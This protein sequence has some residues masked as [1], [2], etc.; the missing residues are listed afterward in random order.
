M[1]LLNHLGLLGKE[2]FLTKLHIYDWLLFGALISAIDP[3]A[4]LAVLGNADL[5]CDP[6]L[7]IIVFG[8]AVLNDAVSI[9]LFD[10][11][12]DIREHADQ[13]ISWLPLLQIFGRFLLM[14]AGSLFVGL[15]VCLLAAA[16]VRCV[17]FSKHPS[18]EFVIILMSSYICY[19]TAEVLQFSGIMA[20]YLGGII[21]AHYTFYNISRTSQA[22]TYQLFAALAHT[23]ET[24]LYIYVGLSGVF[25]LIPRFALDYSPKVIGWGLLC[26]TVARG[27]HIFP[28]SAIVN[29]SRRRKITLA[30]Q[31]A[32]WLSGLRGAISF[33]LSMRLDVPV[34]VT[35]T[36]AIVFATTLVLGVGSQFFLR[37]LGLIRP[38]DGPVIGEEEGSAPKPKQDAKKKGDGA[39][40]KLLSRPATP[41]GAFP[42]VSS[43]YGATAALPPAPM[44]RSSTFALTPDPAAGPVNA[45][46]QP[47]PRILGGGLHACWRRLD[48]HYLQ[49]WFGGR[50]ATPIVD[51]DEEH[52][53]HDTDVHNP[54]LPHEI[55]DAA[56]QEDYL[57]FM[58]QPD[59]ARSSSVLAVASDAAPEPGSP[60]G[61][62]W[63]ASMDSHAVGSFPRVQSAMTGPRRPGA[64][65][66]GLG[67]F[68]VDDRYG[69]LMT[70]RNP[71]QDL[72]QSSS[73]PDLNAASPPADSFV[74]A[75]LDRATSR[76]SMSWAIRPRAGDA[77]IEHDDDDDMDSMVLNLSPRR[78]S[79][80][81]KHPSRK[82]TFVPSSAPAKSKS[83]FPDASGGRE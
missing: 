79:S 3:V 11:L 10:T 17:N 45:D 1:Y 72:S 52:V 6:M 34:L 69:F 28:L 27:L 43:T 53:D 29:V 78:E 54:Y 67:S 41:E 75:S 42:S 82:N 12:Y 48:R 50:F 37:C 83:S 5:R 9:V 59:L 26:C 47:R 21:Q 8:E 38:H 70:Y 49:R 36:M 74:P 62:G 13:V 20:L 23:A 80:V 81:P 19:A 31:V 66:R 39:K 68:V 22:V 60:R 25:A 58:S 71:E 76:A 14:V 73:R 65:H 15:A 40:D 57:E 16:F 56:D 63:M 4:T 64:H 77:S 33:A 46:A 61:A 32:M 30:M 18:A 24:V 51:Y 2:E 35:T 55:F 7:Y 44:S